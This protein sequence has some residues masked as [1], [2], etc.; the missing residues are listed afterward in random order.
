MM[1]KRRSAKIT[2]AEINELQELE[3]RL[4]QPGVRADRQQVMALLAEEFFEIGAS[5]KV[6]DR[7]G[8][9]EALALAAGGSVSLSDFL[10]R[11]LEPDLVLVTYRSFWRGPGDARAQALRS[12]LWR[13][14]E[15]GWML[16]FHQGTPAG[17]T[18][19]AEHPTSGSADAKAEITPIGV[20]HSPLA[21]R[22]TAPRHGSEGG[23]EA[24]LEVYP[25]YADG[26]GGIVS[27]SEVILLTWLH[28]SRRDVLKVHPRRNREA[29]LTGVFATRSP[30]RPNP[31]GLHRVKVLSIKGSSLKVAPLEAIDGTPVADIKPVLDNDSNM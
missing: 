19:Q 16:L 22:E 30:D 7:Q 8:A 9:A 29:P 25:E 23:A 15:T 4:L 20:I 24:W 31:L 11:A 12:S 13:R 5:G 1:D 10:A 6:Y 26:L 28:R 21:D 3:L 18:V 17:S 27:G 2:A 14:T